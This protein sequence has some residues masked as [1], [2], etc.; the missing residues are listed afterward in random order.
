[1]VL[2]KIMFYLLKDGCMSDG[3][4]LKSSGLNEH[5]LSLSKRSTNFEKLE[6]PQ[7]SHQYC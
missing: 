4:E 5:Q 6:H 3:T 1:M 2:S 7:H